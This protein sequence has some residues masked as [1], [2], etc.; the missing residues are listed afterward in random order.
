MTPASIDFGFGTAYERTEA[1]LELVRDERRR[2]D[3]LKS[4]GRF[5]YTCADREMMPAEKL[6]VLAEELGEV[7]REVLS[8]D[9][10]VSDGTG[11]NAAIREELVQVAAIA[12]AWIEALE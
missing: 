11:T 6:A 9:G 2:Q 10:L 3:G 8:Q 12:V 4:S 1:V 5:T 7:A